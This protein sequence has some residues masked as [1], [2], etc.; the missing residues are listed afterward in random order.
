LRKTD[1]NVNSFKGIGYLI[2]VA[3]I[4]QPRASEGKGLV[5]EKINALPFELHV[6]GYN[7]LGP[8]SQLEMLER[9]D[10]G[11]NPLDAA[12]KELHIA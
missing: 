6:P 12:A 11:I 9:S 2:K 5:N 10:R 3:S 1:F 4:L 7:F 8:G